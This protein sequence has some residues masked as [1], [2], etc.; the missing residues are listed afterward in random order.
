[1]NKTKTEKNGTATAIVEPK[2]CEE[3]F[4]RQ[5]VDH[6]L[7]S[8]KDGTQIAQELGIFYPRL[9][10]WKRRYGGDAAPQRADLETENR[11]LRAELTR[12]REQRDVL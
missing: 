8:V 10:G 4:K 7:R 3:I 5:A 9:N 2:R 11:P 12:V 6:W 1:M